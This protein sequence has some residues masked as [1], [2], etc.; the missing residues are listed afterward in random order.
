MPPQGPQ[1]G[2]GAAMT[3]SPMAGA[4][5]HAMSAVGAGLKALQMALPGLQM[6]SP[7]HTEV[8]KAV[9]NLSKHMA[10]QGQDQ[11]GQIQQLIAQARQAQTQPPAA[12]GAMQ[13]MFPGG[14]GA[15][16]PEAGQ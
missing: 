5:A 15:P 7:L 14:G 3:P 1:G 2:T 11:S 12:Q 13:S 6:G 16:P 4:Q 9:Q 8:L 10:E